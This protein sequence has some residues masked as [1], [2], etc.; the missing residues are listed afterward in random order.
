MLRTGDPGR[1]RTQS[2]SYY[3]VCEARRCA[4]TG[5]SHASHAQSQIVWLRLVPPE[6]HTLVCGDGVQHWFEISW[7]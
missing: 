5:S 2:H 7:P 1:I 3:A 6:N 4:S